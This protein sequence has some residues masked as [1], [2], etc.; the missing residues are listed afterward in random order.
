MIQNYRER[1]PEWLPRP[2]PNGFYRWDTSLHESYSDSS[3]G[4]VNSSPGC[5]TALAQNTHYNP[6]DD[7]LRISNLDLDILEP[8][9][10]AIRDQKVMIK[11]IV[12][13]EMESIR[14]ELFPLQ[15]GSPWHQIILD[16]HPE[17]DH[18]MVNERL[19]KLT[20]NAEKITGKPGGFLN[21]AGHPYEHSRENDNW[22]GP[23]EGFGGVNIVGAFTSSSKSSK[24]FLGSHC[25]VWPL[26]VDGLEEAECQV[27][28]PC[29]PQIL[30]MF[31]AKKAKVTDLDQSDMRNWPWDHMFC[32]AVTEDYD[33]QDEIDEKI[34]FNKV[35]A[36]STLDRE[37]ASVPGMRP[38]HYFGYAEPY[39]KH[40]MEEFIDRSIAA[41]TRLFLS[42]FTS[43][44]H[45]PW[46]TPP[47]WESKA[48][49]GKKAAA[50][51]NHRDF[52]SYLDA[53]GFHDW[54]LGEMM[55]MLEDKGIADETLVVLVGDHGQP[56]LEDTATLGTFDNG[57]ASSFRVPISLYHPRLP[58]VQHG[59]NA[60]AVSVL[61]TVLDLLASSGSLGDGDACAARDLL[62]DYEGQSLIRPYKA[63]EDGRR[64]WNF[65]VANLGGRVR[66]ISQQIDLPLFCLFPEFRDMLHGFGSHKGCTLMHKCLATLVFRFSYPF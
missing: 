47:E 50:G 19:S 7:P 25:G 24:A 6:V 64:A 22:K 32:Q 20:P 61:P 46:K 52:D 15:Q 62:A 65:G 48:Y 1:I 13:I 51:V 38:L 56:F 39:T 16:S 43:S 37:A 41:N 33:R 27:Y 29:L 12:L 57:H 49:M 21:P 40:H 35:V 28:Q 58:R 17:A 9:E 53:V 30:D 11:H 5:G 42:H 3:T 63:R 8:L 14:E 54:W 55:R 59:A 34:G 18:D 31:N 60:T 10:Q 2:V 36:S 45:H 26:A 66:W 4:T 23:A 44:T